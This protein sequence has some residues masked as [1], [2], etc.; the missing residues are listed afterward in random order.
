MASAQGNDGVH[1]SGGGVSLSVGRGREVRRKGTGKLG[2][3]GHVVRAWRFQGFY[4]TFKNNLSVGCAGS[5]LQ[6]GL[7]LVAPSRGSSPVAAGRLLI[8]VASLVADHR[9]WAPGLQ[10]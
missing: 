10:S 9:L 8:V 2:R 1:S 7:F 3:G 4:F 6:P 5:S